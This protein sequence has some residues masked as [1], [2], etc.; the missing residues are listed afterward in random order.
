MAS[1]QRSF[2]EN[3]P[4]HRPQLEDLQH[5]PAAR[6]VS[7]GWRFGLWWISILLILAIWYA[8]WGWGG[9]GGWWFHH[10][11]P[12]NDALE[13]GDGAGVLNTTL[14]QQYIGQ[15]FQARSLPVER[16]AG[17][18]A[19]WIG[20]PFNSVPTLLALPAGPQTAAITSSAA[21]ARGEWLDVNGTVEA[22]PNGAQA[23]QWWNL[24]A[25]DL[26]RLANQGA[27]VQAKGVQIAPH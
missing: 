1:P 7:G 5:G 25:S 26:N 15:A 23:K 10:G 17:P 22:A 24:N 16:A 11:Q 13:D 18:N 2:P 12:V 20:S 3:P 19:V 9:H 6:A 8:G 14:K 27:F 21:V 4:P